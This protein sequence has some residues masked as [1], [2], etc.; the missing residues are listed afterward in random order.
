MNDPY[1]EISYLVRSENRVRVLETLAS[2]PT[3]KAAV[4]EET[5]ISGVTAGRVL[6]GFIERGWIRVDGDTFEATEVGDLLVADYRRLFDSMDLACR[7]GPVI[8]HV[9]PYD[10]DFDVRQL[11]DSAVADPET[12]DPL[13]VIDRQIQLFQEAHHV[14]AFTHRVPNFLSEI[15]FEEV[16]E[17]DLEME[18]I[19]EGPLVDRLLASPD[20]RAQIA[21][22]VSAGAEFYRAK[23]GTRIP[24]HAGRFDDV[25]AMLVHDDAGSAVLGIES[26]AE[27]V[28]EWVDETYERYRTEGTRIRPKTIDT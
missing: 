28:L 24:H 19:A 22:I 23:E 13:R 10:M 18:F 7:L 16:I 2:G 5:G 11:T 27:P 1:E 14:R 8:E 12:F 4:V 20:I 9:P 21:Q 26:S 25:V 3:T 6:E 15:I 17:G